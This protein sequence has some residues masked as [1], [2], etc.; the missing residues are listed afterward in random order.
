M[1]EIQQEICKTCKGKGRIE[2]SPHACEYCGWS[3][4]E[5][6]DCEGTGIINEIPDKS[7]V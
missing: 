2:A 6:D 1:E 7:D 3:E 5:C 4:Y